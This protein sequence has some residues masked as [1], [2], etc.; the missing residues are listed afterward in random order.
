[1]PSPPFAFPTGYALDDEP[2]RV[3]LLGDGEAGRVTLSIGMAGED[4][5]AGSGGEQW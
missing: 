5:E 2:L 4:A 1:M 3:L